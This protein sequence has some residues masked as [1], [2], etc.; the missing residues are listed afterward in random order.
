MILIL[1][2]PNCPLVYITY[3]TLEL[4]TQF[5]T[6]NDKAYISPQL[7]IIKIHFFSAG[8]VSMRQNVTTVDVRFWRIKTIPVL[9]EFKYFQWS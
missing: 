5:P 6:S 1:V 7:S 8:T 4:E 3:L 2:L 9:E